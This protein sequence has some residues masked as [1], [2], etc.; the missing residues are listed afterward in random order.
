[1]RRTSGLQQNP[2]RPGHSQHND[3]PTRAERH[4]ASVAIGCIAIIVAAIIFTGIHWSTMP[5]SGVEPIDP[6]TL[7]VSGEFVELNLGA[8]IQPDGQAAGNPRP[9]GIPPFAQTLSDADIAAV[10]TYIRVSWGNHGSPISP[11]DA[12]ALRSAPLF[13]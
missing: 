13:D 12:N 1:M 7:H 2:R 11:K 3:A 10:V 5:P 4:W 6:T 9:Y 8:R